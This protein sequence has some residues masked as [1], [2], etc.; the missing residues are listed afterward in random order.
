VVPRLDDRVLISRAVPIMA[1]NPMEV[2]Q[3]RGLA[4]K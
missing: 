2:I 4:S 3:M 1:L